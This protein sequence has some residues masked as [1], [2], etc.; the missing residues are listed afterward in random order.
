EVTADTLKAFLAEHHISCWAADTQGTPVGDV[1]PEVRRL[2]L[3]ISNEG[4]GITANVAALAERRV[5][6]PMSDGV[7][8]LNVAVA[9]GILLHAFRNIVL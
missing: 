2:A 4:A 6:I 8:S 1:R 5:A 3:V 9:T 7:E